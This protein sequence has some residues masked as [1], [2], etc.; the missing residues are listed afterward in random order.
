[1]NF[2]ALKTFNIKQNSMVASIVLGTALLVIGFILKYCQVHRNSLLGYRTYRS[3][4]NEANWEFANNRF[5]RHAIIIG[6]I[7]LAV[8]VASFFIHVNNGYILFGLLTLLLISIVTIEINLSKFDKK[9]S[10]TE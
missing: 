4:K 5:S 8:G 2:K 1:M 9:S 10:K 7:S 3:M 6:L